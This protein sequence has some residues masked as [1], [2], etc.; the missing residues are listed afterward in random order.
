MLLTF[1]VFFH[2][3]SVF[4]NLRKNHADRQT[5]THT[6]T[7]THTHLILIQTVFKGYQQTTVIISCMKKINFNDRAVINFYVLLHAAYFWFFF[8][9]MFLSFQ[10]LERIMQT[11][12][13]THTHTHTDTHSHT[14]THAH[15]HLI[16]IQTVFKGYQ[17]TTVIL[18]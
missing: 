3:V 7:R 8:L 12:R 15:T 2:H 9:T 1:G 5:D 16:L 17:Q 4:S 18:K 14:H 13:Q 11:D 6:H 10:I